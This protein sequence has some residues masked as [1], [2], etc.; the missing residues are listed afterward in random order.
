MVLAPF[1]GWLSRGGCASSPGR[2]AALC[3]LPATCPAVKESAASAASPDIG[4]PTG[5]G[6][7]CCIFFA[8]FDIFGS[9]GAKYIEK[10]LVVT[11]TGEG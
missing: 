3:R 5:C 9:S 10:G 4:I 6:Q 11:S 8:F 2:T 7:I 1:W